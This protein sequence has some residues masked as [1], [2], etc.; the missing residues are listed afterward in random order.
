MP[1]PVRN[2]SEDPPT[3]NKPPDV[4][5]K[6]TSDGDSLDP[7]DAFQHSSPRMDV[8]DTGSDSGLA[9]IADDEGKQ[10]REPG[11]AADRVTRKRRGPDR[12]GT[13]RL[14]AR[15]P[16]IKLGLGNGSSLSS[17]SSDKGLKH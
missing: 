8:D 17:L 13:L 15:F 7:Q 11:P 6:G 12:A 16:T 2:P 3:R 9:T 14:K 1:T 10:D 4:E 5:S